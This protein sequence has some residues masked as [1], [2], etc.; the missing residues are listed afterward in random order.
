MVPVP[1]PMM[2][3]VML[4]GDVVVVAVLNCGVSDAQVSA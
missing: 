1:I 3:Y 2:V 4:D